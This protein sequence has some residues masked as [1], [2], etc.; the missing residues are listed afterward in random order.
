MTG[1]EQAGIVLVDFGFSEGGGFKKRPALV[2]SSNEYHNHR[3]EVIVAAITS[4]VSRLLF[5]DTKIE[6]WQA[7]G[8]LYPSVV[9]GILRTVHARLILRQLGRLSSS[10][11]EAVRRSV[12]KAIGL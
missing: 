6:R 7:A 2:V 8:L 4:N 5:G 9:T 11:W 3:R 1:Y 12:K 10:D